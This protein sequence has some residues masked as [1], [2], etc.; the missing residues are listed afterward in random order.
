[1]KN[2]T[3]SSTFTANVSVPEDNVDLRTAAS[4]ETAFQSL[5]NRTKY[6]ND[7]SA[8]TSAVSSTDN[9]LARYD[10]TTGKTVQA[11]TVTESDTG[12]LANVENIELSG[13]LSYNPTK[14]RTKLIP[15]ALGSA[16][17]GVT[18]GSSFAQIAAN[19]GLLTLP[20]ILDQGSLVTQVRVKAK[21]GDVR[22]TST[23][24]IALALQV[25]APDLG[26]TTTPTP[27]TVASARDNGSTSVQTFG[28]SSLLM[29]IDN[30][31]T[32]YFAVISGG[33]NAGTNPDEIYGVEVEY[34][35]YGP[36]NC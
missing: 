12:T 4:V 1:M 9:A 15:L 2:L 29:S 14:T 36:R 10:G 19:Y 3:E 35:D 7:H 5:T 13:E 22:P 18:N 8:F 11:G 20:I 32:T 34:I 26:N 31:S 23:D 30:D 17:S 24:R 28:I 21:P 27:T 6:L 33:A 16:S 25:F